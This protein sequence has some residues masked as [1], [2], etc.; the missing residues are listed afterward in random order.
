MPQ[1]VRVHALGDA[2][3]MRTRG[4]HGLDGAHGVARVAIALEQLASPPRLQMG[5]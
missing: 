3:L 1:Q 2:R 4:D 5:L